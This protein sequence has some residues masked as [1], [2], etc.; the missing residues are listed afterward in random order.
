MPPSDQSDIRPGQV[1]ASTDRYDREHGWRQRRVVT[2]IE[3]ESVFLQTEG[4]TRSQRITVKAGRIPGHKL[5]EDV[6]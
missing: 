4:I 3:G 1:Y 5:V 6:R 2:K